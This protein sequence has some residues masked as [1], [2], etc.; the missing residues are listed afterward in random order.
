MC[1]VSTVLVT[2]CVVSTSKGRNIEIEADT[3]R[4]TEGGRERQV[5][6]DRQREEGE[7]DQEWTSDECSVSV[8][9]KVQHPAPKVQ[10]P[11]PKVQQPA[12]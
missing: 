6:T 3:D 10:H 12:S 4:Q 8:W 11:A 5:Q 2:M 1:V 9:G 7:R